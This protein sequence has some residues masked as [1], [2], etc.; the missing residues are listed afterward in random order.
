MV[1][2]IAETGHDMNPSAATARFL[3]FSRLDTLFDT[4]K[5]SGYRCVG[6]GIENDAIMFREMASAAE[7]G[8][9]DT[10]VNLGRNRR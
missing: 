4:L 7:P 6:P 1:G 3:E 10:I 9:L 8:F 5:S 2:V